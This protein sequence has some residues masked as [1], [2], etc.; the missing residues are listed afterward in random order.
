MLIDFHAHIYPPEVW[1]KVI[2]RL[3]DFYGVKSKWDATPESLRESLSRANVKKAVILPVPIKK[4]HVEFNN[5][6]YASLPEKFPELIPFGAIH[7]EAPPEIVDTFKEMG[8]K[9]FKVQPNA[10]N[11]RPDSSVMFPFYSRAE[12]SGLIAVFHAGDEEGGIEG[13]YSHPEY[14]VPILEEFPSLKCVFAHLGGYK[15]WDEAQVLYKYS[16][17]FF[18]TSYTLGILPPDE[19]SEIVT[20]LQ[21]RVVFG[22]DFPF[23]DHLE[24]KQMI[25]E[26]L[27]EKILDKMTKNAMKL[28]EQD[29]SP[30]QRG[31]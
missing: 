10:W 13:R 6:S 29:D 27:G 2:S 28:L 24:E 26:I 14:F 31:L 18:D 19:F 20:K 3:E 23:R 25:A 16:Q 21:D 5:L 1:K 12:K 15:R 9:G 17:A 22:T 7:P 8:F 30:S 4:E 11:T